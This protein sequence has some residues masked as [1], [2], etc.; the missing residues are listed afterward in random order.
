MLNTVRKFIASDPGLVNTPGADG[1]RPLHFASSIE[2]IDLLLDNGA[3]IDARDLDHSAT[4]AQYHVSEPE[5]CRHLLARGARPDIYMACALGDREL[6]E[7]L[8]DAYPD[9]LTC[10]IGNCRGTR[11]IDPRSSSHVY[12]WKLKGAATPLEVAYAF[13]HQL[14]FDEIYRRSPLVI[15]FLTACWL[16]DESEVR[17]ILQIE[18][19][20]MNR[21]DDRQSRE[22]ARAAWDG[23]INS[24]RVMVQAGFDPHLPGDEESTPLDRA[25]FHGH[26]EIVELLLEH[27]PE[28][29]LAVLN[30]YGSTPLGTCCYGNLN[31][32]KEGTDHLGTAEALIRAG[33]IINSQWIPTGDEAMDELLRRHV[34]IP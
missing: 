1:Q 30:F 11:P 23:R 19:D 26:R 3:E 10:R 34:R 22:M 6:V 25:A 5:L 18:P 7:S 31:S 33:S 17:R 27:D 24:V 15:Q 9:A 12:A 4:A 8:L 14:V 2:L 29:P 16:A 28:P 32:W 21:L 20:L 13:G